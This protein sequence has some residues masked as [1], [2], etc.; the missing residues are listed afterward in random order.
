MEYK[1][2]SSKSTLQPRTKYKI[3]K[4]KL[5]YKDFYQEISKKSK[6]L[7]RQSVLLPN[8]DI[9][10]IFRPNSNFSIIKQYTVVRG[11]SSTSVASINGDIHYNI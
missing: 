4:W 1:N 8:S 9:R 5:V 6:N 10:I 3:P 11:R 7:F 2:T